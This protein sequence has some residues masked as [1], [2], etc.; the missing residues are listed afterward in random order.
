MRDSKWTANSNSEKE[1]NDWPD[2]H[3][4]PHRRQPTPFT[5][6]MSPSVA[7]SKEEALYEISEEDSEQQPASVW[8][9]VRASSMA[10]SNASN[11]A[12]VF[13]FHSQLDRPT[14]PSSF[15][16]SS[17]SSPTSPPSHSYPLPSQPSSTASSPDTPP[18]L[19]SGDAVADDED[20]MDLRAMEETSKGSVADG[21]RDV[22]DEDDVSGLADALGALGRA[23][24]LHSIQLSLAQSRNA[25]THNTSADSGKEVVVQRGA[26]KDSVGLSLLRS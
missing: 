21:V 18:L 23:R 5:A 17:W 3:P 14:V 25:T 20:L 7:R 11:N 15:L 9:T 26:N 2:T 16:S 22:R 12:T 4:P 19:T 1:S 24:A 10:V 6:S 8:S 13:P